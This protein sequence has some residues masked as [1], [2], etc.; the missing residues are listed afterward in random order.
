MIRHQLIQRFKDLVVSIYLFNEWRGFTQLEQKL[1]PALE[2]DSQTSAHFLNCVKKHAADERRHFEMFRAYFISIGRPPFA[3]GKAVGFF[4]ALA[5]CVAG[6]YGVISQAEPKH[7]AKLCQVIVLTERR[8]IAQLESLLKWK[9]VSRD[10]RLRRIFETIQM[11]EPSHF[12]PYEEWLD[13]HGFPRASYLA[14]AWDILIHY[15]IAG[16]IIPFHFFNFRLKRCRYLSGF[17]I[18]KLLWFLHN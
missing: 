1:I 11:D 3:V 2:S 6:K 9:I 16:I 18:Y 12:G 7:F 5:E 4:D 13:N 14:K 8:G 15:S 10:H 17:P